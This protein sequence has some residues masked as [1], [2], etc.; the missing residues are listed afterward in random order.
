MG[1]QVF[2]VGLSGWDTHS[3]QNVR[4]EP[5]LTELNTALTDFQVAIND[6][7]KANTVTTFTA[8]DF[9]RTLTTNGD[10]TDHGWG[11]H[12]LVMGGAV[13]C[14]KIYGDFPSFASQN[15]PDDAGD[16]N[17]FA[18]RIIPKIGVC[19]FAAT[20]ADWMGVIPQ[21]QEDM[22]TNLSNFTTKNLE[23]MRD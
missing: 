12:S 8:S 14:G 10:G 18:G 9:G 3:N 6:M 7:G 16:N 4:I 2:F 22:L 17:N 13:D 19:Q 5:L 15:N 20:L 21:E 1:K 23:F 11:G